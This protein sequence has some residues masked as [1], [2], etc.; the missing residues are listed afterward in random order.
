MKVLR[1]GI[2]A[3]QLRALSVTSQVP[4]ESTRDYDHLPTQTKFSMEVGSL[5]IGS[6]LPRFPQGI[7]IMNASQ[8]RALNTTPQVRHELTSVTDHSTTQTTF[9]MEAGSS[10]IGL[11]C[12]PQGIRIINAPKLRALNT[13]SQEPHEP[14]SVAD[15]SINQTTFALETEFEPPLQGPPTTQLPLSFAA[16]SPTIT[17]PPNNPHHQFEDQQPLTN[18]M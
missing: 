12:F 11:P 13:T 5:E 2:N 3:P 18:G 8:L 4:H 9:A 7:R 17:S 1:R 14:V 16:R 10:G 6:P 15:H